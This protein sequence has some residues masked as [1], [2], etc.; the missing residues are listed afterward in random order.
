[1]LSVSNEEKSQ[2]NNDNID[3]RVGFAYSKEGKL[4]S[5]Q[6]YILGKT[7]RL[8]GSNCIVIYHLERQT[9]LLAV[10]EYR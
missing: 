3:P 5:S 10:P 6:V 2:T 7:T 8:F 9:V 1:M 4:N